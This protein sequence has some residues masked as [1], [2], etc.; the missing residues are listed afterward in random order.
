MGLDRDAPLALEVHGIEQL[1]LGIA[2]GDGA[3]ELEQPVRKRG[4]PVID[5]G[6]D[7][8]IPGECDGHCGP[9]TM[10]EPAAAVKRLAGGRAS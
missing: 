3:R 9:E 6:D 10:R 2:L 7:A 5:M 4:L 1:I 8:E